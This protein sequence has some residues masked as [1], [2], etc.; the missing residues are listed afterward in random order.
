MAD[1]T[2]ET[3]ATPGATAPE[4][5]RN[6]VPILIAVGV[7]VVIIIGAGAYFLTK[8]DDSS[9]AATGPLPAKLAK[10]LYA[11]WQANDQATAAKDATPSTVTTLFSVPAADGDGLVFGGCKSTAD[12]VLPK[13]CV[14]S[15]PGGELTMTVSKVNGKRTV[16]N[17]KYGAA[18]TTPTT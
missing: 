14:F 10:N 16:T 4:K 6:L 13:A 3:S 11:A 8:D 12:T 17:V 9:E 1:A 5:K 2:P 15:R 18:A 7:I